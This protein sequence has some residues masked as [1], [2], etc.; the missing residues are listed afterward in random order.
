[1][2]EE[3]DAIV[4]GTG[5]KECIISGLL[6]VDGLKVGPRKARRDA[7]AGRCLAGGPWQA[8]MCAQLL[9]GCMPGHRRQCGHARM[10]P[11]HLPAAQACP[12][13]HP[14]LQVLHIDRNNYYGGQSASL[15]LNQVCGRK[16]AD[17]AR[18][19]QRSEM[20]GRRPSTQPVR[21]RSRQCCRVHC[22]AR[23]AATSPSLPVVHTRA[24]RHPR[25]CTSGSGPGRSHQQS[26]A[27]RGTTTWTWCPSSS[28]RVHGMLL[29]PLG[30]RPRTPPAHACMASTGVPG[31]CM[32]T[33]VHGASAGRAARRRCCR[34]AAPVVAP[35]P[36]VCRFA[37]TSVTTGAPPTC[38]RGPAA[39][40][41]RQAHHSNRATLSALQANGNLVKVL[42]HTDVTKYLEFKAVDGSYVLSKAR[43][44]KVRRARYENGLRAAATGSAHVLRAPRCRHGQRAQFQGCGLPPRAAR[45]FSG[46]RAASS[47]SARGRAGAAL[48]PRQGERVQGLAAAAGGTCSPWAC[49]TWRRCGEAVQRGGVRRHASRHIGLLAIPAGTTRVLMPAPRPPTLQVPAT[50]WEALKSPLMGLFEKR[51]AAK[52][53]SYC[54]QYNERDPSVRGPG[55]LAQCAC[56]MAMWGCCPRL[57]G[58]PQL[59]LFNQAGWAVLV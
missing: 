54:Q 16:E 35:E 48:V 33:F 24:A 18:Q 31:A 28:W 17:H 49:C 12:C 1:M 13:P 26:W 55:G 27:P 14:P 22:A 3:Y 53:F 32:R 4:L 47:G 56:S 29:G 58:T 34:A 46:L 23:A 44:E 59:Y 8:D 57:G 39:P 19:V 52:F 30:R 41:L 51:R 50:D 2:D 10:H 5:F 21:Q 36:R 9:P 7:C 43:V 40:L 45:T 25:S 20:R 15:N 42:V 6:S 37:W 38:L 11:R